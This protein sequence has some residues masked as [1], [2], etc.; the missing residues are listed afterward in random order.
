M[1]RKCRENLPPEPFSRLG[2]VP[3]PLAPL[4][5][6]AL[7]TALLL[8]LSSCGEEDAQL[9]PGET[10]R[11]ITANLDAVKQLADEGDC[12]GAEAASEQVSEQVEALGGVDRRLKQA[13]EQGT[14]RLGEVI[15]GCEEEE[16]EAIEPAT[17]PEGE[18][19][20]EA[21]DEGEDHGGNGRGKGQGQGGQGGGRDEAPGQEEQAETTPTPEPPAKPEGKGQGKGESTPPTEPPAED[22]PSGGIEP[23]SPVEEGG[24]G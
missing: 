2:P 23:G 18:E 15:A 17:I 7:G 21:E 14:E 9:L 4:L 13:L 11:E 10:A 8:G 19:E 12:V 16:T 24:E 3:R 20:P 6:L 5:A 22:G 1:T